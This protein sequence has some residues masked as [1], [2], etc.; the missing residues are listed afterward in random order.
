MRARK[1]QKNRHQRRRNAIRRRESHWPAS[2]ADV[3]EPVIIWP[4]PREE[5][6]IGDRR[7][8]ES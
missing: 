7:S 4:G 5:V 6:R 8:D 1:L 2:G 3:H